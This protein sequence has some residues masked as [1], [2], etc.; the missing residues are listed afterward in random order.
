MITTDFFLAR[1]P[2]TD[3]PKLIFGFELLFRENDFNLIE[4]EDAFDASCRLFVN[5]FDNF[6]IS[7]ILGD[8]LGFV[9]VDNKILFEDFI[10][11]VPYNKIIFEIMETSAVNQELVDRITALKSKGYKF[12]LDN[13]VFDKD[14]INSFRPLF[15]EVSYIKI[16]TQLTEFERMKMQLNTLKKMNVKLIAEK[17]ET[18]EEFEQCKQ[19]GF[20]YFQGYYFSKPHAFKTKSVDPSRF[21]AVKLL[22]MLNDRADSSSIADIFKTNP[23][24]SYHLL[25]FINSA[26]FSFK[27][28]IK[29]IEHAVNL[30]GINRLKRWTML[31]IY[32]ANGRDNFRSP[33]LQTAIMRA[34]FME[35]L[36]LHRHPN[37]YS[38]ANSA[39]MIGMLSL[40][41]V[42]FGVTKEQMI[43]ELSIDDSVK[44]ALLAR[45]GFLGNLLD[46]AVESEKMGFIKNISKD[47][48]DKLQINLKAVYNAKMRSYIWANEII[49]IYKNG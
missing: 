7:S 36:S 10:E 22:N 47:T 15:K 35:L 27:A 5:V 21:A 38:T 40:F 42:F 19:I 29:S 18:Y 41:D 43:S 45:K 30:L 13:F 12:A 23:K 24:L 25:R 33:L 1:Q 48:L 28:K 3:A 44:D 16:N 39:Y 17:V 6:D 49:S 2:I 31:I 20:D 46:L 32:T 8:S 4:I 11:I 37:L 26:N 9:N 34:N 14:Y